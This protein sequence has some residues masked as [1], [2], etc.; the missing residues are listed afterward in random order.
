MQDEQSAAAQRLHAGRAA[1]RLIARR[2]VRLEVRLVPEAGP[3]LPLLVPPD[4]LLALGPRLALRIRRGTVVEDPAIAR[5]RPGPLA[6]D[7]VLL[8]VRLLTR[9]LVDAV[10]VDARVDPGAAGGRPVGLE[11][12]VLLDVAARVPVEAAYLHQHD[13]RVRLLIRPGGRVVPGQV[14]NR[15][16]LR[17]GGAGELLA[18]LAP[19]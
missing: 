12:L 16:I 2:L 13:V 1:R 10:L 17:V 7:P 9:R 3:L 11:L 19:D 8:P 14:E 18:D 15:P 5:P 4:V 6:S